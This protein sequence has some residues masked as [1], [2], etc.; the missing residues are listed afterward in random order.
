M[1]FQ[2]AP[3]HQI[4]LSDRSTTQTVL[5]SDGE[6]KLGLHNLVPDTS[7][8]SP[9][10]CAFIADKQYVFQV[11]VTDDTVLTLPTAEFGAAVQ[12]TFD[13]SV[14]S[15]T[16]DTAGTN[17]HASIVAIAGGYRCILTSE[18]TAAGSGNAT[19]TG[20]T[21][22]SPTAYQSSL[23]SLNVVPNGDFDTSD[24]FGL[25]S[26]WSIGS[27]VATKAAGATSQN[28][29][30]DA[31]LDTTNYSSFLF[32]YEISSYTDG[33]LTPRI[34]S[35]DGSFVGTSQSA[36][37]VYSEIITAT[38]AN[39]NPALRSNGDGDLSVDWFFVVPLEANGLPADQMQRST[40]GSNYIRT[41][42]VEVPNAPEMVTNGT[43]DNNTAGW[44]PSG[45]TLSVD[46]GRMKVTNDAAAISHADQSITT[47]V[48]ETYVFTVDITDGTSTNAQ[49]LVGN[50][51]GSRD[52]VNTSHN[53][54]KAF[55]FTATTTTTHIR[56]TNGNAVL[57][58]Y[59]FFDDISVKQVL[60]L[61]GPKY[62]LTRAFDGNGDCLGMQAYAGAT[63]LLPY[64]NFGDNWTKTNMTIGY[65]SDPLSSS[66]VMVFTED[67]ANTQK[68]IQRSV[69][70]LTGDYT[71]SVYMKAA[72]RNYGI[73]GDRFT[74]GFF[75]IWDLT[76]GVRTGGSGSAPDGVPVGNG[77]F[78]YSLDPITFAGTIYG[79]RVAA[80]LDGTNDSAYLGDGREA[81]LF[82]F[83]QIE[84]GSI[85]TPYIPTEGSTVARG[86]DD[87]FTLV[88]QFGY[89]DTEGTVVVE[90]NASAQSG[91]DLTTFQLGVVGQ[92]S[93][94][95]IAVSLQSGNV[96][97]LRVN[98][99][100]VSQVSAGLG[101]Y[102]P[103]ANNVAA[104]AFKT[105]D[106]GGSS[107]GDTAVNDN[108]GTMPPVNNVL[109]HGARP[110]VSRL[111]N[112]TI[113][114]I[115]YYPAR[116]SDEALEELSS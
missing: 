32:S 100:S 102:V 109:Y 40:D 52:I 44:T 58:N 6:L 17:T 104:V 95:R 39:A 112:G 30:S 66:G 89:N 22:T 3:A 16:V 61:S 64:S 73:L 60:Q 88:E 36:L 51:Q 90:Y 105:D 1:A 27:G 47:V 20:G 81:F 35:D 96:S 46:A 42:A 103:D 28:C 115:V 49:V 37:G 15:A 34:T 55:T 101:T 78:R 10:S 110:D 4:A 56:C 93:A 23:H 79:F 75:S 59:C 8:A 54:F 113:K 83:G 12:A 13:V 38:G 114:S 5:D 67:S 19:A 7:A 50:A 116:L 43:F 72:G 97:T 29:Q 25:G 99:G 21:P 11:D 82:A 45:S 76:T 48:G 57:G 65:T 86:A 84:T 18:A 33:L 2:H 70:S 31:I 14:P 53:G 26:D 106:F 69:S 80:S 63:N 98:T 108:S 94:E 107:N 74:S 85:A 71:G 41:D 24:H 68:Y 77:W 9:W 62:A 111:L 91:T 87:L 92:A